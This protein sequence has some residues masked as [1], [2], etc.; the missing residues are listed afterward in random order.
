[1]SMHAQIMGPQRYRVPAVATQLWL[2]RHGDAEAH[3]ARADPRRALTER[4]VRQ[5]RAA[6]LALARRRVKLDAVYT[7]PRVR[8]LD[9]ARLACEALNGLEPAVYAPL[10]A[11]FD[12][13][14]A[15]ELIAENDSRGHLMVVGHEPDF[16]QTIYDLTGARV[17]LKKGGLAMV[18]V[19][20]GSGQLLLLLRPG[21]I[22][23]IARV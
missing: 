21:E 3:G 17:D 11:G 9:T 19:V 6:G 23:L 2:L 18:R 7:S 12:A 10:S 20:G 22:E 14:D 13:G 15:R 8:A 1:M 5:A 16:S 4:G